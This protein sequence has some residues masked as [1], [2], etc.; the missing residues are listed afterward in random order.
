MKIYNSKICRSYSIKKSLMNKQYIEL[1]L[2]CMKH[3]I[4]LL[5]ETLIASR[6]LHLMVVLWIHLWVYSVTSLCLR[7]VPILR[8]RMICYI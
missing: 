4:P 2:L 3:I 7:S 6:V 5:L 1:V 8:M